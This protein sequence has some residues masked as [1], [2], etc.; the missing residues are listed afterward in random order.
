M[1]PEPDMI[2]EAMNSMNADKAVMI[3]DQIEDILAARKAGIDS[4]YIDRSGD[5]ESKADQSIKSMKELPK[6]LGI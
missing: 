4:V 3:G 1:K 2:E 5:T 6:I